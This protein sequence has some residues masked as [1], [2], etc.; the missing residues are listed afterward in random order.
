MQQTYLAPPP[1]PPALPPCDNIQANERS[2]TLMDYGWMLY[3][4]KSL[5]ILITGL[6]VGLAIAI[7]LA[8]TRM[9]QSTASLELQRV[10]DSYDTRDIPPSSASSD[11]PREVDV[12]TQVEALRQDPLLEEVV[13]KLELVERPEYAPRSGVARRLAAF[14][15]LASASEPE[16][17]RHAVRTARDDLRVEPVKGSRIIHITFDAPDAALAANFANTLA[18]VF[19]EHSVQERWRR[20]QQVREWLRPQLQEL[21]QKLEEAQDRFREYSNATGLILNPGHGNLSEDKLRLM[22]SELTKAQAERIAKEPLYRLAFTTDATEIFASSAIQDY[23]ARLTDLRRQLAD[24]EALFKPESHRVTRLKAQIAEVESAIQ[25]EIADQRSRIRNDYQ[26]A[27]RREELLTGAWKS[28]SREV[29]HMSNKMIEYDT[30]W[31]EVETTRDVY[32]AMLR[33]MNETEIASAVQPSTVRVIGP[34]QPAEHPHRP[35]LPLNL[36]LG[37]F[38]GL[39]LA[40]GI[41]TMLEQSNRRL[42]VPGDVETHLSVPELGAIPAAKR[43]GGAGTALS[44]AMGRKS[45]EMV[46]WENKLSGVSESFR[47]TLASI[48]VAERNG[49]PRAFVITSALASEGKTTVSC[50]LGIA[51]AEIGRRVLLIDADLRRPR[52][53]KVFNLSNSWGLSSLL[54]GQSNADGIP[55]YVSAHKTAVPNLFVLPSGPGTASIFSLL[56]SE[57]ARK[58]ICG[59]REEFDHVLID[60]PPSIEFADARALALNTQGVIMVVRADH[61]DARTAFAAVRRLQ[62]DGIPVVGAVLNEWNPR[63]GRTY[64]YHGFE[65]LYQMDSEYAKQSSNSGSRPAGA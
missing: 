35:N 26:A 4:R 33:K 23:Q 29:A 49:G 54:S 34:A 9:Y 61:T 48:L 12:E 15:G 5:L 47:S 21:K 22:Q 16:P 40:V 56:C 7:S 62:L 19:I 41:V 59:F 65:K 2:S 36:G 60:A 53:H 10:S 13:K 37:L 8:Q 50:N 57:Q 32:G 14:L 55:S 28:Q 43:V 45:V 42:C 58:I 18:E 52:L 31:R 38:G 20:S 6:V 27:V 24:V 25:K 30:L 46:T 3:R 11:T 51:L 63:T 44:R 39:S 64:G 1:G 17:V